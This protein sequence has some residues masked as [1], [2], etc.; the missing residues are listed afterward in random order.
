MLEADQAYL[1]ENPSAITRRMLLAAPLL[2]IFPEP[3]PTPWPITCL[4]D[5]IRGKC[6]DYGA[7]IK[8]AAQKEEC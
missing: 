3:M 6:F 7:I 8:T 5:P 4:P 2:M 1:C